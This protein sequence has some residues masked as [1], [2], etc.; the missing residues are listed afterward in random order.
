MGNAPLSKS[1]GRRSSVGIPFASYT[2]YQ[3]QTSSRC[4]FPKDFWPR[5]RA[6]PLKF[7]APPG[8]ARTFTGNRRKAGM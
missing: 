8:T 5:R 6:L 2:G 7:C 1:S 4:P 3:R